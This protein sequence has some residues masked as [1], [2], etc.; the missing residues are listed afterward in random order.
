[1][2]FKKLMAGLLSLAMVF[3][4]TACGG[5][6]SKNTSTQEQGTT[7][8]DTTKES[9]AS[10]G[11]TLTVAIWDTNQEPGLTQ[12]INDFTAETGI[13]AQIQV[14]PWDQYWTMLEAG[15]TGGSL[16]DVFWMHSNEIAKYSQYE[17]LLDLTDRIK[18]SDKVDLS[19]FPQDIV[20]I[21]NWD[22][23]Q[24]AVP[25]DID[26]IA[27]WYNKTMFDEA[28]LEYPNEN[29]TWDDFREACKKLTKPDGSQYGYA[30]DPSNNQDGWYNMVYAMGGEIISA[31]KKSSGFDKEGTIKAIEFVTDLV[32]QGYTPNYETMTENSANALFE[33]GKVAM[34]TMGSWMLPELCNND[35]VKEHGDIAVLP[36][37]AATGRRISIYNGLGWAASANTSMPEEAWKLIEYFGSKEAQQKQSDLGIVISAYEGTTSNWINAYPNFNLQAYLDMMGDL[38]IRP[39]SRSTV[40]WENMSKEKLISA[41]TGEKE[42]RDVCLEIAQ[43]MNAYLAQE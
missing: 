17:M 29:W 2:V 40:V 35:Y 19:K 26:T 13:K 15:A 36:K 25:K 39:Y 24:Y 10:S 28:G 16:P 42:A 30:I 43:E 37:D 41:W 6:S 5:G 31:D 34:I 7:T 3:S 11:K 27:L 22:G 12:I 20:E 4:L 9:S 21:Y 38:V 33:A 23:K 18:S 32:K 14:T 8:Q 1:M